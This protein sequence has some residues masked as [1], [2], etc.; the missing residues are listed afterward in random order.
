MFDAIVCLKQNKCPREDKVFQLFLCLWNTYLEIEALLKKG[1]IKY[2]SFVTFILYKILACDT[3]R[4]TI[5][6]SH[7][8]PGFYILQSSSFFLLISWSGSDDNPNNNA[9][10]GEAGSDRSNIILLDNAKYPFA[11]AAKADKPNK[12]G[13]WANSYPMHLSN[14]TFLGLSKED[15]IT[16]G[17]GGS[18]M[19]SLIML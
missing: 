19:F 8:L 11:Q 6:N 17:M 14:G 5:R 13:H 3:L 12:Y 2:I 10:Q 18:R 9:G 7:V 15:A 16:L 1:F 4:E